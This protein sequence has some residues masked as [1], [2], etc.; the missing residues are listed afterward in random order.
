MVVSGWAPALLSHNGRNEVDAMIKILFSAALLIG[1]S[2][3][4][5]AAQRQDEAVAAGKAWLE[6][7]DDGDYAAAW[8]DVA[9]LFKGKMDVDAWVQSVSAP[10]GQVGELKSRKL[11]SYTEMTSLPNAPDGDYAIVEFDSV[12][13]NRKDSGEM[14]P[15]VR[16]DGRW[17]VG[18][19]Y[20]K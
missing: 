14:L 15:L 1:L 9:Q 11:K 12:F 19:Y 8:S 17:K 10:R 4:A 2:G 18:G 3:P 5:F 20:I 16:E 13:A 7:V 6:M